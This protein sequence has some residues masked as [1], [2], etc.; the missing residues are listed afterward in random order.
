MSDRSQTGHTTNNGPQSYASEVAY[1]VDTFSKREVQDRITGL[2]EEQLY[3]WIKNNTSTDVAKLLAEKSQNMSNLKRDKW[4][5]AITQANKTTFETFVDG[6]DRLDWL[7]A[8][9]EAEANREN[10]R[11]ERIGYVNKRKQ[12]LK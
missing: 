4:A 11:G 7:T 12:E 1:F 9:I 8:L 6:E 10:P 2:F 3:E 5:W